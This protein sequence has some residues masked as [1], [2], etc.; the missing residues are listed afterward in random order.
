M[1]SGLAGLLR[2]YFPK[3]SASEVKKILMESGT[4]FKMPVAIFDKKKTKKKVLFTELSKSGKII[5][6]YNA[7]KMAFE[8]NKRHHEK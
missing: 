7:F 2:S 1:V 3:L 5:N 4:S 6:A 8:Q